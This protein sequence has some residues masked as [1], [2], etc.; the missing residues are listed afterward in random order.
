[1]AIFES[2]HFFGLQS[3]FLLKPRLLYPCD[4]RGI[5]STVLFAQGLVVLDFFGHG[6]PLTGPVQLQVQKHIE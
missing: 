2:K 4:E 1:M 5:D 6:A 3:K